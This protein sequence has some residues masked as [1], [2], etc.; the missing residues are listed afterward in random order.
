MLPRALPTLLLVTFLIPVSAIL[1]GAVVLGE[2]LLP[3]H[4]W[5][6]ALIA[7]DLAGIEGRLPRLLG[8]QGAASD[9]PHRSAV[10]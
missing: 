10:P 2:T 4:F 3:R 6:M 7:V 9:A 1:L 5:D 8:R